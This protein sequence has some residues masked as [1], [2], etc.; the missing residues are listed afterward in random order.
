MFVNSNFLR[1][2]GIV[3]LKESSEEI[4]SIYNDGEGLAVP[5]TLVIDLFY[6]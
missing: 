3:E 1:K 5:C 6:R 4:G 2:P